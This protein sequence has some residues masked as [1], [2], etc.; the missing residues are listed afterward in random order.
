M[1]VL[2]TKYTLNSYEI[3]N[4]KHGNIRSVFQGEFLPFFFI[5]NKSNGSTI[6]TAIPQH[7][8]DAFWKH[9]VPAFPYP[10]HP[11]K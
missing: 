4:N 8:E 1:S 11:Y 7:Q 2:D 5:L 3:T 9:S 6:T 10:V